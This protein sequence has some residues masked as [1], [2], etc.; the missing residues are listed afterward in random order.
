MAWIVLICGA[1]ESRVTAS[2][3]RRR[4]AEIRARLLRALQVQAARP[5][6]FADLMRREYGV[7]DAT[8][9][10]QLRLRTRRGDIE[11]FPRLRFATDDQ[12]DGRT[13]RVMSHTICVSDS[14]V[15]ANDAV[16]RMVRR[17]VRRCLPAGRGWP[18]LLSGR[19]AGWWRRRIRA[20]AR[21][22][23]SLLQSKLTT[24][25]R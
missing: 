23:G 4:A 10:E 7:R 14:Y 6:T 19:V 18:V 25:R 24:A 12:L 9:V 21:I 22:F 3:S 17:G 8:V 16:I 5:E 20:I 11:W 13:Y 1:V 15:H 2:I